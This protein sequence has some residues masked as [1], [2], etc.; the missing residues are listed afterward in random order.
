MENTIA[1]VSRVHFPRFASFQLYD[2]GMLTSVFVLSASSNDK[3]GII[4]FWLVLLQ[5]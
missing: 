5:V 1:H 2:F 3:M 4:M